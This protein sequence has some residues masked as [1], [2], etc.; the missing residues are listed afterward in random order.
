MELNIKTERCVVRMFEERDI[1]DFMA[2]RNN[3]NWMRYQGFKG[4][5]RQEYRDALLV[6]YSPEKGMQLA[7]ISDATGRLIGDMYIKRREDTFWMGCTVDPS[8]AHRGYAREA[9]AAVMDWMR[10]QGAGQVSAGVLPDNADSIRLLERLGLT[11]VST[12]AHGELIYTMELQTF[13]FN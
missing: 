7:I 9:V 4:L 10:Q 8:H 3:E 2:Y 13:C 11:H 1:D 12:D 6:E 5:T